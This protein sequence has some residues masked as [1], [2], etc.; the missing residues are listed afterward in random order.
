MSKHTIQTPRCKFKE[1]SCHACK[2]GNCIALT[3][4]K[5]NWKTCPF[6]KTEEQHRA[7]DMRAIE[8]LKAARNYKALDRY[9]WGNKWSDNFSSNSND[10]GDN[11]N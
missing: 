10:S 3:A 2:D 7:E 9:R 5:Q 1:L 8:R 4:A 11:D 6:F